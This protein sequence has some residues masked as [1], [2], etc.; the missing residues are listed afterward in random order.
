MRG[1][2]WRVLVLPG[3][4]AVLLPACSG[5]ALDR[6]ALDRGISTTHNKRTRTSANS[7]TNGTS[8]PH[9]RHPHPRHTHT[10]AAAAAR[11]LAR[12]AA[13]DGRR[14][15][16]ARVAREERGGRLCLSLSSP[17][18]YVSFRVEPNTPSQRPTPLYASVSE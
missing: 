3:P 8:R 9:A 12:G 5:A 17:V 2:F 10:H 18:M 1:A 6:W 11:S 14:P 7:E 4:P 16:E 13:A 15:G